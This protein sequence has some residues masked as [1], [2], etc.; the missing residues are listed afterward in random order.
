MTFRHFSAIFLGLVCW[1]GAQGQM[2]VITTFAGNGSAGFSGDGGAATSAQ[3][4]S[5]GG[6]A[7]DSSG[8]IYVADGGNN[9]VRKISNGTITTVAGNGTAGYSGDKGA[10]TSAE[11]TDPVGVA[12]DSSG[13]LYIADAGNNVIREVSPAGTI[14]TI[15][16]NNSMGAGYSG[17]GAAATS[18]Q[19][20]NPTAVALDSLG[21]LYITDSGND[22]IREVSGGNISTIPSG[23]LL[24]PDGLVLDSSGN[25]YI[26]DTG[27]TE[28][29]ELSAGNALIFAGNGNFG[30]AGDNGSAT[31]AELYDPSGITLDSAGYFYVSDMF[32]FRIRKISPSGVI[33]TIAGNG[34]PGYSGDSGPATSAQVMFPRGIVVG[35]SGNVYFSDE[36]NNVIRELQP[37]APAITSAGVVNAASY[38]PQISAGA[39]ASIFGT[40][41]TGEAATAASLPLPSAVG[42]VSVT[43]NGISAPVLYANQYQINFQVPWE[44]APSAP[45][46]A[47]VTVSVNGVTSNSVSVP[48]ATAAPGLFVSNG[49]AVVQNYPSYTLNTSG[50]PAKEGSTI[51]AYLTGSGPVNPAV[52]D[53]TA[54]P[55]SPLALATLPTSAQIGSTPASVMFAGLAPDF[56]GLMQ[57]N[58]VVPTG[59][60]AGNYPLT[61]TVGG[62]TSNAATISITP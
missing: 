10:A 37:V 50:N 25:I 38:G 41:I 24:Q 6:L 11:L 17:D 8:N 27:G 57:V 12:V 53:G 54:A 59:L 26:A 34:S 28:I 15:A 20:S 31:D 39:L 51:I 29:V 62:Q 46:S 42:G 45:G 19:I 48:L 22:V 55:S 32:N 47:N 5:P 52:A 16:G 33:T 49:R 23:T 4:S 36:G 61:V 60:P 9:R 2:Y 30:F 58:I 13:N 56:A 3:L 44:V 14:T 43:V 35:S 1:S 18:A 7:I 40:N 21:N